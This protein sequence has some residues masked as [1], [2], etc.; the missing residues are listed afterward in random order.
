MSATQPSQISLS[1]SPIGS[2]AQ[3]ASPIVLY[4]DQQLLNHER[5]RGGKSNGAG[6]GAAAGGVDD[7]FSGIRDGNG[8]SQTPQFKRPAP[9]TSLLNNSGGGDGSIEEWNQTPQHN[10]YVPSAPPPHSTKT[11]SPT[12]APP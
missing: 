1:L 2:V 12:S 9:V 7:I 11:V 3:R 6:I 4:N 8:W 5:V 10:R